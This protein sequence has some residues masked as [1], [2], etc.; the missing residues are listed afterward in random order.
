MLVLASSSPRRSELLKRAAI[1]FIVRPAQGVDETPLA[2]ENP[3][4]H[5]Q[6]L[7]ETKA[8][9]VEA[10]PGEIVLGADTVVV[11]G[12]HILGK[13]ADDAEAASMLAALSG[14]RHEVVTG[15]CLRF[16]HEIVRD[17]ATTQVWFAE[18]GEEE[19]AE[20][21]AGGEPRDKA[22]AYAIQGVASRFIERIDGGYSNVV[23][24]PV[25]LV[26]KHLRARRAV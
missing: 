14:R 5:V 2:R 8:L 18:L 19:I 23:G 24:L 7:A 4:T 20:Y 22:G 12:G 9:A 15:I 10:A 26:W 6:R 13:P 1:D 17:W 11:L 21:V 25:S 3:E 16:D